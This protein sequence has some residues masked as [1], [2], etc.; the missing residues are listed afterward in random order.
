MSDLL[1]EKAKIL[2]ETTT[3]LGLVTQLRHIEK[4]PR[5]YVAELIVVRIFSMFE[6]VVEDSA[7]KLVCGASYCDGSSSG[8]IR[9]RPTRGFQRARDAMKDFNRTTRRE[10]LR[11]SKS[12]DIAK[13]LEKLFPATETFVATLQGHGQFISDLRKIRNHIA[14][15]NEGTR[16]AFQEA[17]QNYY[18]AR[19]P[20]LTPGRMLLSSRFSPILVE[21]V[22]VKTRAILKASIRA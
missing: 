20:G 12:G 9:G 13:N 18:G 4:M 11:W 5:Q 6:A 2:A 16:V 22:C 10:H 3:A 14:H 21:Q 1:I 15:G 7:C 19:V 17:V 8:L